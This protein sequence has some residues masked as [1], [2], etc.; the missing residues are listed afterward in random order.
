MSTDHGWAI[1]SWKAAKHE[2]VAVPKVDDDDSRVPGAAFIAGDRPIGDHSDPGSIADVNSESRPGRL[3][4][5]MAPLHAPDRDSNKFFLFPPVSRD[6][7][8]IRMSL[9]GEA[10]D[11][12]VEAGDHGPRPRGPGIRE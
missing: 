10:T 8:S 9:S 3:G 2:E 6:V 12:L 11:L 4:A 7:A 1:A 5:P